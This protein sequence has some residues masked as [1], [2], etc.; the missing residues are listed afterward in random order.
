MTDV[1]TDSSQTEKRPR[2]LSPS[3]VDLKL[4]CCLVGGSKPFPVV[5]SS[6]DTVGDLKERVQQKKPNDLK[7]V[8]ADNLELFLISLPD[9]GD[10]TKR[11]EDKVERIDP[12]DPTTE[13][14]EIFPDDPPKKTVHIAV[15]LPDVAIVPTDTKK[16]KRSDFEEASHLIV[17]W[18]SKRIKSELPTIAELATF[19]DRPLSDEEKIPISAARMS[20][21]VTYLGQ[22]WCTSDDIELLFRPSESETPLDKIF[23]VVA[24]SPPTRGTVNAF[25]SFWDQNVRAILE[26]LLPE[27]RSDRNSSQH[28]A[29]KSLYPDYVFLLGNICSFRGEERSP[30]DTGAHPKSKLRDKLEWVYAPAPYVLGYYTTGPDFTLA[31]ISAPS[32]LGQRPVVYDIARADLRFRRDRIRNICRLIN[33]AGLVRAL[34]NLVRPSCAEFVKRER[35]NSTVEIAGRCVIKRY[36]GLDKHSRVSHLCNIYALLKEMCVPHVDS[37]F[38]SYGTTL[39]LSPRGIPDEPKTE[40]E[41]LEA[42]ICVLEALE[43][44]H[45]AVQPVFHRD[46]RWANVMR[47][48]DDPEKWFVVDW[49]DAATPPTTAQPHFNSATHS[50]RIFV[51]GHGAEVDIWGV[52]GLIIHCS[53][54]ALD[55]TPELRDL[56]RWMQNSTAPSA[57]EALRKIKDYQSSR[58]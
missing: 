49:E 58:R 35:E 13:I 44:L 14:I 19:V 16:R 18:R 15:K 25:I 1:E 54:T 30:D 24:D 40:G 46:I 9:E 12:L 17:R 36:T 31:A 11:V 39:V 27:G 22:N 8:D 41:L 42:L 53:L 48:L 56:G 2:P 52:G 5:I 32:E 38:R 51:D 7:G 28:T 47:R 21:L 4:F 6:S 23:A 50:S 34:A 10:L 37:L 26:L 20:A 55:V 33:L 3:A 57:Q 43:V 45:G 29:T